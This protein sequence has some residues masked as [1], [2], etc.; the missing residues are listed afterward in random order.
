MKAAAMS[1]TFSLVAFYGSSPV[2][3]QGSAMVDLLDEQDTAAKKDKGLSV[4]KTCAVLRDCFGL[5]LSPGGLSQP[6]DRLAPKVKPEYDVLATELRQARWFIAM[7]PAGGSIPCLALSHS[8][9]L[10]EIF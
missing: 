5:Q 8:V 1:A 6:L 2:W 4:R 7:R 3:Y 9:N 10:G